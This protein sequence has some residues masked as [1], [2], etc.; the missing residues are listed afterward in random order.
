MCTYI[1]YIHIWI[2]PCKGEIRRYTSTY[3]YIYICIYIHV[4]IC[5]HVHRCT[6]MHVHIGTYF[7]KGCRHSPFSPISLGFCGAQSYVPLNS[8]ANQGY[9]QRPPL[10]S[11]SLSKLV[12][13]MDT[14]LHNQGYGQRPPLEVQG[15]SFGDGPS[16]PRIATLHSMRSCVF[17]F[18]CQALFEST[19]R[20]S[21]MLLLPAFSF[22]HRPSWLP[23][24]TADSMCICKPDTSM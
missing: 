20:M 1:L 16:M 2:S 11:P 10:G 18:A 3:T 12:K 17:R 13:G 8:H 5:V 4:H 24:R 23:C 9:G 19:W 15:C 14:G 6:Y 7:A 22:S 21:R